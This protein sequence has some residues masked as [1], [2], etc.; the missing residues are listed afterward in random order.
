MVESKQV[1]LLLFALTVF[2]LAIANIFIWA[3]Y[4]HGELAI[5]TYTNWTARISFLVFI[6]AFT[7]STLAQLW[8]NAATLWCLN[9]RRYWGLNFALAHA[10]HLG[11]LTLYVVISNTEPSM[12]TLVFG[13]LAYVFVALMALTSNNLSLRMLGRAWGRLHTIGS[14]YIW[15][16]FAY[17]FAGGVAESTVSL[18][19]LLVAFAALG[20]KVRNKTRA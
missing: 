18:V 19:L 20:L 14:Y 5:R 7:A 1:P 10:V 16:I 12:V 3:S 6:V 15:G 2:V 17:T 11:A 9:N 13:G 8:P 4:G